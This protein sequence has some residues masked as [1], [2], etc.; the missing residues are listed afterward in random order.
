MVKQDLEN[1][2]KNSDRQSVIQYLKLTIRSSGL[3]KSDKY[4]GVT[5]L[6]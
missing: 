6:G 3:M 2:I 1:V 5:L 4:K